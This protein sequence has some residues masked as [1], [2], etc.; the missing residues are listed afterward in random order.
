MTTIR[1]QRTGTSTSRFSISILQGLRGVGSSAL[2]TEIV[3]GVTLAALMIPL[4][5]G[6]AQVAGLPP[7]AGLYAA[8]LPLIVFSFLSSSRHLVASP[9]AANAALIAS[10]LAPFAAQNDPR[11]LELVYAQTLICALI[12]FIFWIFK[13]GFLVNFLSRPVII[14]FIAGLGVEVLTSQIVKIMGIAIEAED[15]LPK[16]LEMLTKIPQLGLFQLLLGAGTIFAIRL[17]K[18]YAPRLPGALIALAI[19]TIVVAMFGLSTRGVSV[20]GEVPSGLPTLTIPQVSMSDYLKLIPGALALC[21]VSLPDILV[22]GRKYAQQSGT[23]FNGDDEMFAMGASNVAAGLTGGFGLGVSASRT[24]A[25][26]DSG[27][28]SQIPSLVAAGVVAVALLFFTGV[29]ALLPIAA[30]AGIVAN[31][32]LSLI[33]VK[34]LREVFNRR[35]SEFWI[36]LI[37]LFCVLILGPLIGVVI[38]F[39]LTTVEVVRRA[40]DPPTAILGQI[41]GRSSFFMASRDE[42]VQTVPGLMIYRFGATLFFA[43]ANAFREEVERLIDTTQ[44]KIQWFVMDASAISDIDTSGA[45]ALEQV[46]DLLKARGI[47]SGASR[48]MP[49]VRALLQRYKLLDYLEESRLFDTNHAAALAFFQAQGHPVPAELIGVVDVG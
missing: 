39:L 31:A 30:L 14:G 23:R 48:L 40:A 15:W 27:A 5:I 43:N 38:A 44:P 25:M 3:S 16:V 11:Y 13:L 21:V 2:P 46:L 8:I 10:L 6:Y 18:R 17:L 45:E 28:R 7:T 26:W 33:D 12:F 41:P 36:A 22:L 29:L 9:D 20:L 42:T 1:Q 49:K 37:C 32:V 35:R 19:A 24:A 4:N 47:I 34:Q